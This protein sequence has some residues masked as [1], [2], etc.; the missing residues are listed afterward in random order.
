MSKKVR[1]VPYTLDDKGIADLPREEIVTILRGA[2]DLI[3]SGGR[4][5]LAKI[6]KGSRD[7]RLLELGLDASP[8][9]GAFQ[10]LTLAEIMARVDWVILHGYLAIE[11]DYR[12][13]LLV[14][15]PRGWEI[16][17]DT[18]A[19]EL[20]AGFDDL[21]ASGQAVYDMTYLKDRS[22]DMILLL[23]DKVEAS[24]DAKYIPLLEAWAEIDYKKVRSRIRG[25]IQRL[26]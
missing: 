24:G 15:T 8:V 3:L 9:Y 26:K 21:L 4:N 16:E 7:K 14:Y 17:R 2:D 20:L 5:L 12:L 11:Y 6:L 13:P 1:R 18:Y 19:T 22:R 10:G 25:V 23:L